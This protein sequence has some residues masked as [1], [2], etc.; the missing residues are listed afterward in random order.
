[1]TIVNR[2]LSEQAF[3]IIR[4]RILSNRMPPLT[5]LRQE[6]LAA[7]L[8]I[9]KIPLRE[10]LT[11]LEQ[12]GL[13]RSSINRGYYVPPLT[14]AEAEEVFA[15]RV[16]IE[17]EAAAQACLEASDDE[18][19]TAKTALAA[20]EAIS[21]VDPQQAV[22]F[23]RAF[24]LALIRPGNR[25]V[26]YLLVERLHVL[27]ERYVHMHLEPAGRDARALREHRDLLAAW[28]ARDAKNVSPQLTRHI[29]L[30]LHDLRQQLFEN[31]TIIKSNVPPRPND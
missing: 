3:E 2:T 7:E 13:L 27:A 20:L 8:G 4:E 12:Y 30:T 10:A 11:R 5:L 1:M 6:A 28:L 19:E 14:I 17:P 22:A 21:G 9:S 24:H 26:T 15:L 16:K 23:N 25:Q 31:E 18:I 29:V